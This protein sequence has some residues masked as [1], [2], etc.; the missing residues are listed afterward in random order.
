MTGAPA[1]AEVDGIPVGHHALLT[2][3]AG[4]Q[5]RIGPPTTG[6]RSYVGV[7]GGIAVPAVLGSR[8]TDTLSGLGPAALRAGDVLPVGPE[9][10]TVPHI[11]V[12]PVATPPDGVLTLRAVRGPRLDRLADAAALAHTEW[13]VSDRSDRIGIRLTGARLDRTAGDELPSEGLVPGAV[14]VPPGGEPVVFLADAPVTGGYP[15]VAVLLR[16]DVDR[17]AQARPGQRVRLRLVDPPW[18]CS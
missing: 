7:R 14:Q 6:V 11:D 10:D 4:Q 12:A 9:P 13:T 3:R 2:L 15:V 18:R 17:A 16:A 8:S 1:T 5:L